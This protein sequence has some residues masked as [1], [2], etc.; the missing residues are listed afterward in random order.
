MVGHL[1]GTSVVPFYDWSGFFNNDKVIKTALIGISRMH[2][3]RFPYD[4]P[5]C[6]FVKDS[7]NGAER[8][9]NLLKE[10]SWRPSA[11]DLPEVIT[12]P[13]LPLDWQWY[14]YNKIREFCPDSTKGIVCP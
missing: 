6:V 7:S 4:K 1:D 11:T 5:G 12:P 8:K 10:T 3:F 9:I 14:L 13:G 2:H